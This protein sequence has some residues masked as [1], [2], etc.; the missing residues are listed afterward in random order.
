MISVFSQAN[1]RSQACTREVTLPLQ[2]SQYNSPRRESCALNRVTRIDSYRSVDTFC[3][4]FSP[5][6]ARSLCL[7]NIISY[8]FCLFVLFF[9][10]FWSHGSNMY[11]IFNNPVN[12]STILILPRKVQ[13]NLQQILTQTECAR[14][15]LISLMYF[16]STISGFIKLQM[17]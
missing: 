9:F 3:A 17:G 1:T 13:S 2:R 8:P 16:M 4:I 5:I 11:A 15:L 6:V 10:V 7:C 14:V 12:S